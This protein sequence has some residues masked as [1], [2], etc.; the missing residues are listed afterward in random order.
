[1]AGALVGAFAAIVQ[2]LPSKPENCLVNKAFQT[3]RQQAKMSEE[4]KAKV[5]PQHKVKTGLDGMPKFDFNNFKKSFF[6][7]PWLSLSEGDEHFLRSR[8]TPSASGESRSRLTHSPSGES[9]SRLTS[10]FSAASWSPGLQ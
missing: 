7:R 5:R 2:T 10:A 9:R 6:P 1:M 4:A 8:P 3:A